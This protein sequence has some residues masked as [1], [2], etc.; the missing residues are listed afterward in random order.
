[1]A[2]IKLNQKQVVADLNSGDTFVIVQSNGNVR[3]ITKQSL[4][5]MLG[6]IVP[7]P[8]T[9]DAGKFLQVTNALEYALVSIPEAEEEAF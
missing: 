9:G 6:G 2:A 7:E 5:Q 4:F 8:Q 3:R 1:M